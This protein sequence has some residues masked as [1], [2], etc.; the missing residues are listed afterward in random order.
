NGTTTLDVTIDMSEAD[1]DLSELFTN[2]YWL[3]GFVTLTDPNDT[4]PELHVPYVGFKGEWDSSPIID[5]PIWDADTY[6]GMTGVVT[7]DGEDEDG[8]TLYNFLGQDLQTGEIDPEK[9]AFSPDGD[10][11]QDDA[12]MILSF[13]RNA[14]EVKFNVLDENKEKV[15]TIT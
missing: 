11:V 4:N 7:S 5:S 6:Y 15:R 13:L 10:G 2:G 9:I 12:L 3:E 8:N 1:A 14:E